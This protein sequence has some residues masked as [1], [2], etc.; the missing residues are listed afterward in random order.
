MLRFAAL[1]LTIMFLCGECNAT[2]TYPPPCQAETCLA[3]TSG[4]TTWI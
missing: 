2:P 4:A 1:L 3:L